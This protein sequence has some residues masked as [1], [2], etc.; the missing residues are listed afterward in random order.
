M[1]GHLPFKNCVTH[2]F[3]VDEHVGE[4]WDAYA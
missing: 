2:G 3:L 1:R 4:G